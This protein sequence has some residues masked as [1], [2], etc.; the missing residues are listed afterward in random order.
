[1]GMAESFVVDLL[2]SPTQC[3]QPPK[4]QMSGG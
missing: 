2:P 1:M 4:I 3:T